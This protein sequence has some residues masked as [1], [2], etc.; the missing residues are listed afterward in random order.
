MIVGLGL[1][2]F[3]KKDEAANYRKLSREW[4]ERVRRRGARAD[5]FL[6]SL[7][8]FT[9]VW[10]KFLPEIDGPETEDRRNRRRG[11]RSVKPRND[12]IG[13]AVAALK[14]E[15]TPPALKHATDKQ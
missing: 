14:A 5:E 6:E 12:Q 4:A 2:L 3:S 9:L 8:K 7:A 15:A 10:C 13:Q 11:S 1:G